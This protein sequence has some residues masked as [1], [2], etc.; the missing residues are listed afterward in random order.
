MRNFF[1][2]LI[3]GILG[4][5][6]LSF[7]NHWSTFFSL[8]VLKAMFAVF[9][10][11]LGGLVALLQVKANVISEARIKWVEEFKRNVAE[12]ISSVNELVFHFK[13]YET[14]ED[15]I[16]RRE[17]YDKYSQTI[18]KVQTLV[19]QIEMNLNRS[20][21]LYEEIFQVL[22][23]IENLIV[24]NNLSQIGELKNYPLL[25]KEFSNLTSATQKAMKVEWNK[26]KK[27]IYIGKFNK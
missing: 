11:L 14:T 15:S 18:H 1:L 26:S 3:V 10:A 25:H 6:L 7:L 27:L 24:H 9:L 20:E 13:N 21:P 12:Y 8:S 16:I 17:Y 2:G 23:R 19:K 22:S 5:L 4:V